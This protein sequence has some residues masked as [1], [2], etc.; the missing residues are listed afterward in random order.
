MTKTK[1]NRHSQKES[2]NKTRCKT[3]FVR[4]ATF[5]PI[6]GP[7][8]LHD[9]Q[10]FALSS[11]LGN[12]GTLPLSWEMEIPCTREYCQ[13]IAVDCGTSLKRVT[14]L[15]AWNGESTQNEGNGMQRG[16]GQGV[17]CRSFLSGIIAKKEASHNASIDLDSIQRKQN[18]FHDLGELHGVSRWGRSVACSG[19]KLEHVR[20]GKTVDKR[21][22]LPTT[23]PPWNAT[24]RLGE[25]ERGCLSQITE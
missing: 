5:Y 24:W 13:H 17:A 3:I 18:E 1:Q 10:L 9:F 12:A 19:N 2:T 14:W 25:S 7:S 23:Q 15:R 20:S 11:T 6:P 21:G 16:C 4:A 22:D 8:P